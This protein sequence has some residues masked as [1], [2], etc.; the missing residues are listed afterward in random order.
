MATFVLIH[1]AFRGG[2]AWRATRRILQAA[3]HQV[4]APDL[5]GAG[6]RAHLNH[7]GLTLDDWV[8]DVVNLLEYEDLREV[9]LVGHSLGGVIIT[10]ASERAAPRIARLV[11]LDAPA[12]E[13]GQAAV[14]LIPAEIRAQF[15]EPPRDALAPPRP[16]T[17]NEGFTPEQAA[18]INARLT[19]VAVGPSCEPVKLTNPAALALPRSYVFC[20]QTPAYFPASFTRQRFDQTGVPYRLLPTGHDCMLAAPEMVA[21]LLCEIAAE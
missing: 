16:V 6:A 18:W 10:A 3:G 7:M 4:W 11:Y 9:I 14:D 8:N 15:G 5:T 20:E 21:A 1:G 13:H 17:E 12:P 19:S 2:W